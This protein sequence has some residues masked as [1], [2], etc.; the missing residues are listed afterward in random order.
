MKGWKI[1][2]IVLLIV[3]ICFAVVC[4][5][6]YDCWDQITDDLILN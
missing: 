1:L 4:F 6:L 2:S 5:G 3:V